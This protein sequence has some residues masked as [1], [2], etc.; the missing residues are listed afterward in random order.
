MEDRPPSRGEEL[1]H[2]SWAPGTRPDLLGNLGDALCFLESYFGF[3]VPTLHTHRHDRPQR[4]CCQCRY[5]GSSR[6]FCL[7]AL[8]GTLAVMLCRS[9]E[10]LSACRTHALASEF[11]RPC[12]IKLASETKMSSPAFG[13]RTSKMLVRVLRRNTSVWCA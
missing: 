3:V 13:S 12:E 5:F 7:C 9:S 8:F 10:V 11:S 6:A 2:F 1:A 4:V